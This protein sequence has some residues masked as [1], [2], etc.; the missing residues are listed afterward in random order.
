MTDFGSD[1]NGFLD[2]D[3]N[4]TFLSGDSSLPQPNS[5]RALTQALARRITTP[6][7]GLFYDQSY[8]IDVRDLVSGAVEP[9][10][11][12]AMIASEC[13][14]DE[15]VNDCSVTI[16]VGGSGPDKTWTIT[17]N[18]VTSTGDV[19]KFVLSVNDV[20]VTLLAAGT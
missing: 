3:A 9:S 11:A 8:G 7:G 5:T 19:F 17:V 14:L 10:T 6:R 4:L 18:P 16:V 13:R 15:R 2:L 20:T 12:A 1:L